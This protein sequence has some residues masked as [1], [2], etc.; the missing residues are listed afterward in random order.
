MASVIALDLL[1]EQLEL[2]DSLRAGKGTMFDPQ[3]LPGRYGRVIQAL[4]RLLETIRC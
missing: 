4:D 2:A 3:D 1:A